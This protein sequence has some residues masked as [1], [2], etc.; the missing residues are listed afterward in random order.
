MVYEYIGIN[1]M[2]LHLFADHA[3]NVF[4]IISVVEDVCKESVDHIIN[5]YLA[6]MGLNS[7]IP[8]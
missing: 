3:D 2:V 6:C 5:Y 4:N 1:N 8:T 7:N